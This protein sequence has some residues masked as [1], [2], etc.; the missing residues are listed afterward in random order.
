MISVALKEWAVVCDL[1]LAGECR[2][3]LRKG[4]IHE[5]SGPGRFELEHERFALYPAWEHQWPEGVKPR[6]RDQVEVFD[7]EP[8]EVT[9][10]AIGTVTSREIWRVPSR[11]AFDQLD[12]LHPWAPPQID[13]RFNYKPDRPLYLVCPRIYRLA[14]PRS[15]PNRDAYKGCRSWVPLLPEDAITD[16]SATPVLTDE[17][18]A[19]LRDRINR[20]I[21]PPV[22]L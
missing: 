21:A 10:R 22:S 16:A 3:L 18:F 7:Q 1:L 20:A 12:D 19:A 14:Q 2:V 5:E 8:A 9:F 4:G 17:L 13:M 6:Y 15:A 11:Q